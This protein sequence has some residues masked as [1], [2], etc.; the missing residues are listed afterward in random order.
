MFV[1]CTLCV[2]SE[3]QNEAIGTRTH[4]IDKLVDCVSILP[5]EHPNCSTQHTWRQ[6]ALLNTTHLRSNCVAQHNTPAV[7][8]RCSTQHTWGQIALLNTTHLRSNCVSLA[9]CVVHQLTRSLSVHLIHS[10]VEKWLGISQLIFRGKSCEKEY[11]IDMLVRYNFPGW[12]RDKV[13]FHS[14]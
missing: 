11:P 13:L 1:S 12:G 7:K 14:R 9:S 3:E 6:I 8:L 10:C 5:N 2:R 4:L